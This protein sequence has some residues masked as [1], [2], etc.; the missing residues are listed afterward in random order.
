MKS[1]KYLIFTQKEFDGTSGGIVALNKL[2]HD[3]RTLGQEAYISH[4]PGSISLN[5]PQCTPTFKELQRD[6]I[7]IYPEVV[8][9]NPLN[10]PRVVR[11]ILN[12][13]GAFG[14]T[15]YYKY[16]HKTD[17]V[18]KISDHFS[19]SGIGKKRGILATTYTDFTIFRNN[20]L[21]RSGSCYLVRK[22]V[23][24][25]K[26]HDDE[27]VM[28]D[29]YSDWKDIAQ[30]F[31]TKEIF[32]CYDIATYLSTLAALCGCVSVVI[33]DGKTNREEWH[34][35][36]PYFDC[37]VAYGEGELMHAKNTLYMVTDHIK[38]LEN[39]KLVSV[40][41]FIIITSK[42]YNSR[43]TFIQLFVKQVISSSFRKIVG[44]IKSDVNWWKRNWS[45]RLLIH[46][47]NS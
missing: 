29:D 15:D 1:F 43:K 37:G 25:K 5:T 33:P 44:R 47:G 10:C 7:V 26:I 20:G 41:N 4:G 17:L 34:K 21:K 39:E 40:R 18:F 46:K 19:Y 27:S 31:N 3:L 9:G 45:K 38:N 11:W 12:T 6:F 36:I 22:G 13:P 2:C 42:Y 24:R 32:Y 8:L 30:I 35:S 28:L 23:I 14:H 16:E